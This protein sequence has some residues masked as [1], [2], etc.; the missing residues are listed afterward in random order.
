MKE[1]RLPGRAAVAIAALLAAAV[2]LGIDQLTKYFVLQKLKPI[3]SVTV[4]SG[5]LEF[6]YIENTGA[7]FG[8][9][10]NSMWLIMTLTAIAFVAIAVVLFRYKNHTLLSYIASTLLI[11]GGIGNLIDRM[12]YGFVV[13][14]IHVMFF[15]YIFNFADCCVTVGA[16]LFVLHVLLI[17][18]REKKAA[19]TAEPFEQQG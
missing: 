16:V 11:A 6:S 2:L 5:L 18:Y 1:N 13:D 17:S 4:I 14:F 10:K 12:L 3:G 8:L 7:A 9:F 19:Q 15:D